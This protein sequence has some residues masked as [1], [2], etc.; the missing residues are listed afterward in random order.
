MVVMEKN[1]SS[2]DHS[3]VFDG[4]LP[5]PQFDEE[6]TLISA[7]PVVPLQALKAKAL[8][9]RR[10]IFGLTIIAALIVGSISGTLLLQ[11]RQDA[12]SALEMEKNEPSV[13]DSGAAGGPA[14]E[15]AEKRAENR[16][17]VTRDKESG[18][19]PKETP[20]AR[21]SLKKPSTAAISRTSVKPVRVFNPDLDRNNHFESDAWELRR[22]ERRNAR[23]AARRERRQQREQMGDDLLRIREIFEGTP[24]P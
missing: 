23:R 8:S 20:S 17:L 5:L 21:E 13:S 2:T 3:E 1:Y 15:R 19:R 16:V 22:A 24:R 14:L 11:S 18:A 10:L 6:A 12:E 4:D 9:R 7:R